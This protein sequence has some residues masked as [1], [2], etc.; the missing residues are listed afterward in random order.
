MG[1]K[2][3]NAAVLF[4]PRV[5][6]H[7]CFVCYSLFDAFSC[8]LLPANC[9]DFGGDDQEPTGEVLM[10]VF[11]RPEWLRSWTLWSRAR[12]T[13]AAVQRQQMKVWYPSRCVWVCEFKQ[14]RVCRSKP[15]WVTALSKRWWLNRQ[16]GLVLLIRVLTSCV[17]VT[18]KRW[19]RLVF[20]GKGEFHLNGIHT[21]IRQRSS[22]KLN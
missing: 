15:G 14:Y 3:E 21:V 10:G 16:L 1:E 13:L 19:F 12:R 9:K 20:A 2:K 18:N 5:W 6:F 11:S 7:D 22:Q 4:P 17:N 8:S